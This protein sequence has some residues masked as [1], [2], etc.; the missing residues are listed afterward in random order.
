MCLKINAESFTEKTFK[1]AKKDIVC[2]KLYHKNYYPDGDGGWVTPFASIPAPQLGE[3]R[4]SRESFNILDIEVDELMETRNGIHSYSKID[5]VI[6]LLLYML[7][8]TS[9]RYSYRIVKSIIPEGTRYLEGECNFGESYSSEY[10]ID[11]EVMIQLDR[12]PI[13]Y[14]LPKVLEFI[15]EQTL[16]NL[17]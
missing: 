16:I 12:N 17:I 2:Y 3:L 4:K 11:K 6:M 7:P 10:L 13:E 15:K 5:G 1:V 8:Y 9:R 14:V